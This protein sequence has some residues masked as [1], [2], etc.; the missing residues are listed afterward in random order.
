MLLTSVRPAEGGDPSAQLRVAVGTALIAA[1][2]EL[3]RT[4]PVSTGQVSPT[5]THQGRVELEQG[6]V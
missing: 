3:H 2:E 1:D 5:W 6:E 4:I